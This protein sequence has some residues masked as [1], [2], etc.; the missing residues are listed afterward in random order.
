MTL[1]IQA[2][3]LQFAVDLQG[4]FGSWSA[5][6]LPLRETAGADF[7]R[8]QLDNGEF[9]D[10]SVCSSQQSGTVSEIE[11]GLVIQYQQLEAED[12]HIYPVRFQVQI[13]AVG[14]QLH[15]SYKVINQSEARVNEVK[16]PFVDLSV[17]GDEE[18]ARDVL[19]RSEGHGHRLVDPWTAID[20]AHSEYMF[21][22]NH[23]I[24][25]DMTYPS[26]SSM[27]WF[28]VQSGSHF[29]YV[30][31][32]DD[33]FTSCVLAAGIG[34][35]NSDPRFLLAVS[36]FPL[37][38]AGE[39][40]GSPV[41]VVAFVPG[42]WRQ[43]S[44]IYRQW[45]N[46]WFSEP[47]KPA[48]VQELRGWQRI[49]M[50][51]QFGKIYF[52]YDDLPRVY[53]EGKAVGVEMILLFGWWKGGFDN[54]Y[55]V[56]EPDPA[57]GG[58]EGL[59]AAIAEVQRRGGRVALYTNGVLIDVKSDYYK[60][61]GYRICRKNIDD[62]EYREH[63]KF[64]N[65]GM[66]L[67]NFG[68]KSFVSACQATDE[69]NEQL[70]KVGQQKLSYNPDSIFYDQIAGHFPLLCF[71]ASHHHG[72]RGDNETVWR[73]HNL[74]QMRELCEGDKALGSEF[75]VDCYAPFLD[76]HHSCGYAAFKDEDSFPELY[77]QTFPE[78]IMSNR[79]IHD[80]RSDFKRQLNFAFVY[81]YR[82]DIAIFRSR[83]TV[84]EV[85]A[86]ARHIQ[87]L[88]A[89]RESYA[90]FFYH[91]TFSLD[92]DMELPEGIIKTEFVHKAG[93]LLVFWNDSMEE[94]QL[95]YQSRMI[96]LAAN[97]LLCEI[98]K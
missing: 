31:R 28:G 6:G 50:K 66:L 75:V 19:Y 14:D 4:R 32:H 71:D 86:Y 39:E 21:S 94:K 92:T 60:E 95:T 16:L 45:A 77:R 74:K 96:R 46:G 36:Q 24:W 22:D 20:K 55:P 18:R 43:G 37:V 13:V 25:L 90:E 27:A 41:S 42:D 57:L 51:H 17:I 53:E 70:I 1:S 85:E 68:Y 67:R 35:R 23:E 63:Y 88:I 80:E 30:G 54:G 82:F 11:N 69:W 3:K 91:G 79:F 10:M 97:E 5:E 49:I 89:L 48:W 73:R 62:V 76:F 87:G 9:R 93:R 78:T 26:F 12:G 52:R 34:P 38:K 58:E 40:V 33:C 84:T 29:L 65:D 72:N 47:Q 8:I 98:V 83:A 81:G 56:Y 7:W 64:S 2:G 61:T 15:F 59:K 44:A